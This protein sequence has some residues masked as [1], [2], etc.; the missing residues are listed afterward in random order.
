MSLNIVLHLLASF[1][2]LGIGLSLWIPL[3][4]KQTF[5]PITGLRRFILLV[6]IVLH[7]IAI[8]VAM[9]HNEY[10]QLSWTAGLSLTMWIVMLIFWLERLLARIDGY[11]FILL[12]FA[13]VMTLL[14][15]IFPVASSSP[16][17]IPVRNEIFRLHILLSL[18]AYSLIAIAAIQ[19]GLMALFDRYLH[20]QKIKERKGLTGLVLQAQPPLLTQEKVLFLLVWIGFFVLTIAI[21]TGMYVSWQIS[22][23]LLPIDHKTIFSI[24]SWLVFAVLLTGRVIWGWRGRLALHCNL[25]GF[26][27][28]LLGYT[29]SRFV[30]DVLLH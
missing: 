3:A 9:L 26:T 25:I 11:L 30:I 24:A 28:L 22:Q 18:L 21:I 7:G 10:I 23:K 27:L 4:Q 12:P 5:S 8:H 15:T 13:F 19:S 16:L 29:G 20:R 2:Y 1:I 14:T 17:I 6:A